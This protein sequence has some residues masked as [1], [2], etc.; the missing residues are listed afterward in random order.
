MSSI[1]LNY[2]SFLVWYKSREENEF[3]MQLN[4]ITF[5]W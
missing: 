1:I 3:G 4:K 2:G 5:K